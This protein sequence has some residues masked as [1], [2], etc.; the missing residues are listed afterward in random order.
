M[1]IF[2]AE[3]SPIC[4]V[5]GVP[6]VRDGRHTRAFGGTASRMVGV[7]PIVGKSGVGDALSE[8]EVEVVLEVEVAETS[9]VELATGRPWLVSAHPLTTAFARTVATRARTLIGTVWAQ[10]SATQRKPMW[11]VA[12]SCDCDERA[13][14]R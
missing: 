2:G 1:T 13:A 8:V 12:L 11:V 6:G 7:T 4:A 5:A 14:G 9:S 10:S 3:V